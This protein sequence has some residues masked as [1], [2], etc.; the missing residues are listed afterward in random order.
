MERYIAVDNVCAWPNL[1]QMPDGR[2]VAAIFNQPCHGLWEG[3]VECWESADGGV[4]W[5]LCGA[6]APH[7]PKTNRMNVAAGLARNGDLVVIASGWGGKD[8]RERVLPAWVCRSTD[9][10][11]AWK[12]ADGFPPGPGMRHIVPFGD[13]VALPDG[14]LG[15]SGYGSGE[16]GEARAFG[17]FFLRS[18]DDGRTWGDHVLIAEDHNETDLLCVGGDRL[19]AASRSNK[20]GHLDLYASDDAGR[21]WSLRQQVTGP[22]QHPAHLLKL[23]SGEVLLSYGVRHRGCYGVGARVS[24]DD[25]ANWY[26]PMLLV[27]LDHAWDGGYPASAQ[28]EDGTIVT[29]YYASC[30]AGHDRYHM[31][32]LRWDLQERARLNTRPQPEG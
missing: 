9:G 12:Q 30:V 8:F 7:E 24:D 23:A 11:H 29:A 16:S 31:G 13:I 28:L 6:P 18:R 5:K 4:F 19:L 15:V 17:S 1:T 2:L 14:D 27:D 32:V 3:D 20:G 22:L 25:G 10:G 26:S 21:T